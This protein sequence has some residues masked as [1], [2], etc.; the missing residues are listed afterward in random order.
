MGQGQGHMKGLGRGMDT[1]GAGEHEDSIGY[2][3]YFYFPGT[4]AYGERGGRGGDELQHG[5]LQLCGALPR[6]RGGVRKC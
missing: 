5:G 2:Q 4:A 3:G 1:T 6:W